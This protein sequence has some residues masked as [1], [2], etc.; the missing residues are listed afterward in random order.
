MIQVNARRLVP[1]LAQILEQLGV[2]VC[3]R[4]GLAMATLLRMAGDHENRP[5]GD[6]FGRGF[7][8]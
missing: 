5:D 8:A 2:Q 1:L 7:R 4:R 3:W 6:P